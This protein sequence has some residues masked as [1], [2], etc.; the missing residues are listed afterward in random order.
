M[1]YARAFTYDIMS[2][3]ELVVKGLGIMWRLHD[4]AC[5][6]IRLAFGTY[7]IQTAVYV[8]DITIN[9]LEAKDLEERVLQRQMRLVQELSYAQRK[10]LYYALGFCVQVL[11]SE[12]VFL[13]ESEQFDVMGRLRFDDID[14]RSRKRQW[15]KWLILREGPDFIAAAWKSE[16]AKRMHSDLIGTAF[17]SR[18]PIQMDIELAGMLPLYDAVKQAI[19]SR[20]RNSPPGSLFLIASKT[21]VTE[22]EHWSLEEGLEEFSWH[23]GLGRHCASVGVLFPS[24]ISIDDDP[25]IQDP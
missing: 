20:G 19:P 6:E 13:P 9:Y 1:E 14:I 12:R 2:M 22:L 5:Q 8:S 11:Y 17:L 3:W 23:L 10:S 15:L 21:G 24:P 16:T 25:M 4:C 7:A 18:D